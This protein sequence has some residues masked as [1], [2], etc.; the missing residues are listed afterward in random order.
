MSIDVV[1]T[2]QALKCKVQRVDLEYAAQQKI[3]QN[4]KLTEMADYQPASPQKHSL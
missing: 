1:H 3:L 2:G 4:D